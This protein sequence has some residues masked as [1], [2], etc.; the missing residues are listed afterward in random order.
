MSFWNRRRSI[1]VTPEAGKG[2]PHLKRSLSWPHLLALG[3][4]GIVGTGI[5]TLTGTAAGLAGPAAML[6][7]MIA[8]I[9]CAC[10][11]LAYA[12]MST[13]I[14]VAGSAYTYSYT[15]IGEGWAWIVGWSLILE[16]TLVCSVVAVGWGGYAS[17]LIHQAGWPVPEALLTGPA[18]GGLIDL[19]AV[20]IALAVAGLLTVGTR[21]SARVNLVLVIVKLVALAGFVAL[22]LP[23]FDTAH[24]TPFMPNGF[25]AH[26]V[27]G[28]KVGVIAAASI[29]FFAFYGF[30]TI[31]TASEEAKN[32]GRDLTIGI[33]GS[34]LLCTVIYMAVAAAA[35]GAQP[36]AGFA[37]SPEPLAHIL[38]ALDHPR[39]AVL[40]GAAAV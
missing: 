21:E 25:A 36:V 29:I 20:L 13:L 31:S 26:E 14:P 7:F 39:A 30:D 16:Y 1:D 27:D 6:S 33:V 22:C 40:I 38:R 15:V 8:G 19:P 28:V 32:P 12:E 37:S 23:A 5:Y 34:M 35:I 9:V 2:A 24:F 18:G 10:A 11:A 3:V 4:G 17:G